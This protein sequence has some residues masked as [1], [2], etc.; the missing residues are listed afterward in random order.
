MRRATPDNRRLCSSRS[1][2]PNDI[3]ISGTRACVGWWIS[4][5]GVL[6]Y[7]S[8]TLDEASVPTDQSTWDSNLEV[9]V[10]GGNAV[11][12]TTASSRHY[13]YESSPTAVIN[14]WCEIDISGCV[15]QGSQVWVRVWA[16]SDWCNVN[17]STGAEGN[18]SGATVS[19]AAGVV[20][21]ASVAARDCRVELLEPALG[22]DATATPSAYVG[23]ASDGYTGN[24]TFAQP[25]LALIA[26]ESLTT[27]GAA[28]NAHFTQGADA[29]QPLF[30][31][32]FASVNGLPVAYRE[33]G[34]IS[35]VSCAH[36]D[37]LSTMSGDDPAYALVGV[38]KLSGNYSSLLT[39]YGA[40][41]VRE[42]P[43]YLLGA[44]VY[45]KRHDGTTDQD[46]DMGAHAGAFASDTTFALLRNAD[47]T[48]ELWVGGVYKNT[49]TL[50]DL[51]SAS[52]T[53][54]YNGYPTLTT[55]VQYHA[56]LALFSGQI[57]GA[58]AAAR[59]AVLQP[60]LQAMG[61]RWGGLA[62]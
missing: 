43:L 61:A 37:V 1:L 41:S 23:S 12:A 26:D 7:G 20:L 2:T 47:R 27:L 62:A 3:V 16:G 39:F 28:R 38:V 44:N 34:R 4:N 31:V 50:A 42:V 14:S 25:R 58:T 13:C 55:Q 24:V 60:M 17:L 6:P 22:D 57:P 29:V 45:T 53:N 10:G 48:C 59:Y 15:A 30:Y 49:V 52:M 33:S 18:K 8:V 46:L 9:T 5:N 35:Y 54:C 32:G 56:E 21:F 40:G 36:A 11:K 19:C 51:S